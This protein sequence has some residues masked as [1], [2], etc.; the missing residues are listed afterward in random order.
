[1]DNSTEES[2]SPAKKQR[3]LSPVKSEPSPVKTEP[4]ADEKSADKNADHSSV[5]DSSNTS[6]VTPDQSAEHN[7]EIATT[8][9]SPVK[10]GTKI[11]D[12][13]E[14]CL[15][16]LMKRLDFSDLLNV[17]NSTK[18]LCAGAC[19]VYSQRYADKF[20]KYNGDAI[21][22]KVLEIDVTDTT[23]E[24]N[25]ARSCLKMLRGFGTHITRLRLNFNG[26]GPRRSHAISQAVTEYCPKTLVE[27][28]WLVCPKNA[29]E[30]ST[31]KFTKLESLR[32]VSGYLGE[33]MTLF[34]FFFP[35][36]RR[37]ELTNVEVSDRKSIERTLHSVVHLKVNIEKRKGMD[38]LKSNVKAALNLNPQLTSF[39]IGANC[40]V[41]LLD[42]I[43]DQLPKLE[44]F[45][46]L[47]PR[48]KFFDTT[49]DRVCFRTVKNFSLDIAE[50]KDSFS[51]I[52]FRFTQ[53]KR[54]KLNACY[55][56]R[57]EWIDFAAQNPRITHLHLLNFHWFYVL[58]KEQLIKISQSLPRLTD[59]VLDWRVFS[60]EAVA[61]FVEQCDKLKKMRLSMRTRP[62]RAA[63]YAEIG[64]GWD[65][66]IDEHFM[67]MER[68]NN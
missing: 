19:V 23:I 14:K 40:D 33:K 44:T 6:I 11:T 15:A 4:G 31:E 51:N 60:T 62:E 35:N 66:D 37:L 38:F 36:L 25:D 10:N 68:N 61:Q 52:P 48:K 18:K 43:S 53:L 8:A 56:H 30:N 7:N 5:A 20:V 63:I 46:I 50:C 13:D 12:L 42:Y 39:S 26:I 49:E 27:L 29:M 47:N 57:D 65:I 67:T 34:T 54:F 17:A 21:S 16:E 2:A 64:Q 24:I 59:F 58:N 45:E 22:T 41:K 3:V 9:S 32:I 55:R 1:M 28:E